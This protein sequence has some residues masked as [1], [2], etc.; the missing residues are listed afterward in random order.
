MV[1]TRF[2]RPEARQNLIDTREAMNLWNVLTTCYEIIERF[3]ADLGMTHDVDLKIILEQNIKELKKQSEVLKVQLEKFQVKGPDRGRLPSQWAGN[4]EVSRDELVA[5]MML[6]FLQGYFINLLRAYRTSVTNDSVRQIFHKMTTNIISRTDSLV[7]YLKLKG[8]FESPPSYL[9]TPPNNEEGISCGTAGDLWDNLSRRYDNMRKTGF[10]HA[11]THD[12]DFKF[13]LDM[14]LNKLKNQITVLENECQ[15]FGI[16]LPK[17]PSE[18]VVASIN[19]DLINDDQ[20]YRDLLDGLQGAAMMHADS[21]K[22]CVLNDRIRTIFRK[23]M[24]EELDYFEQFIK[25]GKAKGWLN[26]TPSF[27]V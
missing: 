23:M 26:P 15:K 22:Q 2:L 6:T 10:Y 8:W 25:Y 3:E 20:M 13:I 21:Y 9:N 16:P 11:L 7:K 1:I 18:V 4:P 27:R 12:L 14:G 17:R 5:S 19:T 24:L